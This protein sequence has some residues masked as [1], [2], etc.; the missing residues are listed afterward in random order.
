MRRT[1]AVTVNE[2]LQD[3]YQWLWKLTL[4][5]LPKQ[6]LKEMLTLILDIMMGAPEIGICTPTWLL[7]GG[8]P[9]DGLEPYK[10]KN[11][12]LQNW[13]LHPNDITGS[14]EKKSK[15][16]TLHELFK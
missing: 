10:G 15:T 3:I 1:A 14:S 9:E 4:L 2:V 5:F 8:E 12:R 16:N 11:R 13:S 6:L 7:W